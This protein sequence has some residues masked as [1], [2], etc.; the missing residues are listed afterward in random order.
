MIGR[1]GYACLCLLFCSCSE[2]K[3]DAYGLTEDHYEVYATITVSG[4]TPR[5]SYIVQNSTWAAGRYWENNQQWYLDEIDEPFVEAFEGFVTAAQ[6]TFDL[7]GLGELGFTM[8]DTDSMPRLSEYLML[9]PIGFDSNRRK[10]IVT[11]VSHSGWDGPHEMYFM[12][13]E[14]KRWVIQQVMLLGV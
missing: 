2:V 4:E 14:K 8:V 6:D 9:S 5:E 13:R 3:T 11:K 7:S 10:A 12:S 1:A